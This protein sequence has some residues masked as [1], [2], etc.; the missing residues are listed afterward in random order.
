MFDDRLNKGAVALVGAGPGDPGLLT[1]RARDR[2]AEAD[3]VIHDRLVSAEVLRLANPRALTLDVGKTP[4]G[5]AW[6]Q[7]DIDA[8]MIRHAQAGARVVRLKSGDPGVFGRLEEEIDALDAAGVAWEVVP[9]VTA[10]A[11]AAA[12]AGVA[13]TRR[14]RNAGLRLVTAHD[15]RGFAELDWRGL[16]RPGETAA[17]YMGLRA[18]GRIATKLIA[19]GADPETPVTVVENASRPE[20]IMLAARLDGLADAIAAAGIKGPAVLLLG[21]APRG[22]HAAAPVRAPS[23]LTLAL[24][25]GF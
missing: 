3:V 11:A 7:A 8:L 6:R 15:A 25:A 19:A 2:L 24:A 16:A 1:L 21:L 17:I 12:D 22:P 9:G 10:A 23:A 5:P 4:Y 13:L 20:R 14:G 18:A